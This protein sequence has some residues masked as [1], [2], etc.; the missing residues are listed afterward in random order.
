[1]ED[2]NIP[3]LTPV[4]DIIYAVRNYIEDSGET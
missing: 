2:M 1:M 4:K 3:T